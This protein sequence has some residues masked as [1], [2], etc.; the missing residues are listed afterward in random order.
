MILNIY[1]TQEFSFLARRGVKI[2]R[3]TNFGDHLIAVEQINSRAVK[4]AS[5]YGTRVLNWFHEKG[6]T[7]VVVSDGLKIGGEANFFVRRMMRLALFAGFILFAGCGIPV[8]RTTII[9]KDVAQNPDDLIAKRELLKTGMEVG[10]VFELLEIKR[11]DTRHA[12]SC[13]C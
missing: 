11:T 6:A 7:E 4:P 13:D 3:L 5:R 2:A 10:E 8:S 9:P 12:R 1:F